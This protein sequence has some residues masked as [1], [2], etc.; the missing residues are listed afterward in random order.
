[1]IPFFRKIRKKMA[2]DNRPLKYA[3]YAIGEIVLVVIGI[4]I[5]LQ[6]NNWN[7]ERIQ[8]SELEDLKKSISSAIKSDIKYL[9][10]IR[11]GRKDIGEKVD[12]VFNNYINVQKPKLVFIDY[13]YVSNTFAELKNIIYYQ[14]NTSS[15]EALKNSIYLSRLQGTDLELLLNSFY[16]SAERLQK[17]EEDYNQSLNNDYLAWSKKF[18]NKDDDLFKRPWFYLRSGDIQEQFLEILNDEQTKTILAHG[19]EE[20]DMIDVYDQQILL[21]EKYIEMVENGELNFDAQTQIDFSGTFYSYSEIDVLNLLVNGKVPS[22]FGTIYA[23]SGKDFFSGIQFEDDAMI[24]TYPENILDWGAPYFTINALNN[25]VSELDFSKYKNLTLEIKGANGGEEFA[26]SMKDKYDL[27]DGKESRVD[28]T[29]S[30]TWETYTV[31]IEKFETADK[32]IIQTPLSFVFVGNEGRTIYVRS[33]Q[34]K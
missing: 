13:A 19:F 15:F 28:I 22:D 2:D 33:I 12:S 8:A 10:L 3:R 11:T 23:Q 27:H 31:P 14:P 34:F 25:R 30:D 1:M 18:R 7:Q 5:A 29:V 20:Y 24:L 16:A 17:Q 4:L 9:N 21:G 32:K 6:I 26:V